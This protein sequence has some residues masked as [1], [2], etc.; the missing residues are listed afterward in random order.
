[1]TTLKRGDFVM[2]AAPTRTLPAM[3]GVASANGRSIVLLFD[4]MLGGWINSLAAFRDDDG[5]WSAIDGMPLQITD[6]RPPD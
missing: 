5:R 4:G 6:H 1:V 3:V 2:V